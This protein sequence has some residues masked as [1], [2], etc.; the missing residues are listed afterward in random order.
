MSTPKPAHRVAPSPLCPEH[1]QHLLEELGPEGLAI[2]LQMGARSIDAAEAHQLGFTYGSHRTGGL[3]LPFGGGFAQLRCDDPPIASDGQ[4]VKY[5]SPKGRKQAAATVGT[6]EPTAA[7]EGLKDAIALHLLTGETVQAI[8]GVSGWPLL[9]P[10]VRLLVYDADAAL[11]PGVWGPLVAAGLQRPALRLAFWPAAIA[12]Q[13]GGACEFRNAGGDPATVTRHKARELLRELPSGWDRSLRVDWQPKALRRMAAM[14][15]K[16]GMGLDVAG[17]LVT[18]A[19]RSLGFPVVR[20][21]E[22]LGSVACQVNPPDPERA[23]K[24]PTKQEL[25][26][27]LRR[28]HRLRFNELRQSVEIDGGPMDEFDL[29]DSF[30]AHVHGIETT[31]QAAKD[32]FL[33]VALCNRFNPVREYLES[34]RNTP[35]LRLLS[36]QEIAAAFGISPDD[37]LSQELLARHLAGGYR[38][39]MEPGYKHDQVLLFQGTQGQGKGKTIAALAPPGMADSTTKVNKGLEDREFLGKLNSC[40]I[41]EF[42]EVEKVL[43]GKDA[44]EFKGFASR[45]MFRYVQKWATV[46]GD[47]P[48]RVFLFATTNAREVLNDHTGNRRFWV[49]PAGT[50]DPDWVRENRDSI[51][52]TVATWVARGLETYIPEGHPTAVAAA[53]RALG[54]QISDPW[55]GPIREALEAFPDPTGDG[56]ALD[57]L[58]CQALGIDE[59]GQI[60]RD[61]Q[62]QLTRLVTGTGFTTH[63]GRFRWQQ[64][65]R[66][67]G[68]GQPR[69]GYLAVPVPTF[70]PRSDDSWGGWNGQKPWEDRDLLSLFQPFQ[71]FREGE[72]TEGDW[73]THRGVH[74]S[75]CS[76]EGLR[77]NVGT[78]GTPH[79]A[80]SGAWHLPVPTR[81]NRTEQGPSPLERRNETACPAAGNPPPTGLK[82]QHEMVASALAELKLGPSHPDARSAAYDRLDGAVPRQRVS[83]IVQELN[84]AEKE[85]QPELFGQEDQ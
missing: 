71:P 68:G 5:L 21:R 17:Q 1:H 76:E 82:S 77:R 35:G 65:R 70:Q 12:G 46:C 78:V 33:Y 22:L 73:G 72:E 56:I 48:A 8:A 62:M 20:A 7:T 79:Q 54:V 58:A 34:L 4:P 63:G 25:Q 74:V 14:A 29:A 43:Q 85:D 81:R 10:S 16:A 45:S 55:E 84:E 23:P 6:G 2:A 69:S 64:K 66:R 40:W 51:W 50:C 57:A 44:A 83:A 9:A 18:T 26:Q 80:P 28:R 60:T 32:S 38:R 3:L 53:E 24:E 19:A 30:L 75:P 15:I 47:H 31:K 11:N 41:F 61:K 52:A 42:D 67:Y 37:H 13:K 49:V 27:F 59:A 39:G 36:P